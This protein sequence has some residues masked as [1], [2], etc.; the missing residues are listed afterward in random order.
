MKV[1][2]AEIYTSSITRKKILSGIEIF[3]IFRTYYPKIDRYFYIYF[4]NI[5]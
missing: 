5:S 2:L 1:H 4:S 3:G